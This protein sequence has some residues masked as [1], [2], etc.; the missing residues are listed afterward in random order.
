M[1]QEIT[2]LGYHKEKQK[3]EIFAGL[4]TVQEFKNGGFWEDQRLGKQIIKKY[5]ISRRPW[6]LL[7]AE[8]WEKGW[9]IKRGK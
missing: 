4:L 1:A 5:E 3:G 9:F 2:D 6:F 7:E 8:I